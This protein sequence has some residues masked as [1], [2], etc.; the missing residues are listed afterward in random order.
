MVLEIV[1]YGHPSLRTKGR[2]VEAVNE[3]ILTLI[4]DMIET[5]HAADGVGLAA[6]Q[7]GR[8]LQLCVLDVRDVADRPS[9]M[10]IEGQETD[11]AD[12]MP[13]VLLNPEIEL[14]GSP[15]TGV[16]GC[17]SFPG[18][19][20]DVT[21]P[22][23]VRVRACNEKNQPVTFEAEGLLSRAIQHEVDHLQGILFIDR[24]SPNEKRR[25]EPGLRKFIAT[26]QRH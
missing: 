17:L 13:M 18:L 23:R 22:A 20:A 6:Q 26:N 21:R 1:Q 15:D 3:K 5:M 25:I 19:T 24:L 2:K 12:H 4:Q 10:W 7:I 8:P 16:E 14:L 9:R 11:P